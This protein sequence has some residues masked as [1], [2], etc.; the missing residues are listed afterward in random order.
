MGHAAG[1]GGS[2]ML[3]AAEAAARVAP[4]RQART[5]C[6]RGAFDCCDRVVHQLIPAPGSQHKA[7]SSLPSLGRAR[8]TTQ[9]RLARGGSQA[10]ARW[11]IRIAGEGRR[12]PCSAWA[13]LSSPPGQ[14][15]RTAGRPTVCSSA[16]CSW[17]ARQHQRWSG[18]GRGVPPPPPNAA[19]GTH[20]SSSGQS[21]AA[22]G[23]A[24]LGTGARR[25]PDPRS[26]ITAD[27]Q[28]PPTCLAR[29]LPCSRCLPGCPS[30]SCSFYEQQ[31]P[32]VDE[33]VMVQVRH[34]QAAAT[35]V[36]R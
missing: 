18:D 26:I 8:R 36:S 7:A 29:C 35:V 20:S 24:P 12:R 13:A 30:R 14:H 9:R 25:S 32:E 17:G 3:L 10:A 33:V 22:A 27:K 1:S 23:P 15:G 31:Y 11:R 19:L 4:H 6:P 28:L 21:A 34:C 16:A 2:P 5:H